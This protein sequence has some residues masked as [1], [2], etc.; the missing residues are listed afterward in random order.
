M[1]FGLAGQQ[2]ITLMNRILPQKPSYKYLGLHI[3][4][5]M[6]FRDL[7]DYVVEKLNRFSGLVHKVRHLHPSI[8]LLLFYN[9][10][11]ESVIR[12]GLLV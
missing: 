10:Y 4:A 8:C 6:T 3:D 12:Y 9:S 5:K 7:I 1:N 2:F 11:A